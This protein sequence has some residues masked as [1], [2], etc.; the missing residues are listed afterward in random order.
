VLGCLLAGCS[1]IGPS[2][3]RSGWLDYNDAISETDNQQ[4]L[5]SV[6]HNRY[7]ERASLLAVASVTA[8]VRISASTGVELGFGDQDN[9]T[10][11]LTPLS[12]GAVYE[13]NPTISYVPVQGKKY[14]TPGLTGKGLRI[15]RSK[16]RPE[17]A[18][19]AVPY[20]DG[21]FYIDETDQETKQYFRLMA[22]LWGVAIAESAPMGHASPVLTVP[23]SR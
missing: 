3:I 14:S 17:H 9:Y 18:T 4:L 22:T 19:V 2:A 20:R 21:W 11:N 16:S 7:E 5:M 15:R 10:G 1:L 12:A 8:N 23:V 13:E 6:I